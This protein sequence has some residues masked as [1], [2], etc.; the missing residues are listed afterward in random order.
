M[1]TT[2]KTITGDTFESISIRQYGLTTEADRIRKANPG[3]QEPLTAGLSLTIPVIPGAP[4]NKTQQTDAINESE[5]ALL[6]DNVRFRFWD[7]VRIIRTIDAIDMVEFGAPND[8]KFK[9]ILKPFSYK[10][11]A[12]TINEDVMFT[13]NMVALSPVLENKRK[14]VSVSCYSTPGVLN[15]CTAP[16]SMYPLEFN[17]TKLENIV[18][19]LCE[20]FGV[21]VIV[22]A[23]TGAVFDRATIDPGERIYSFITKLA[24][25]RNIIITNDIDGNLLLLRSI[26]AGSPVVEME[27]GTSPILSITPHFNEQNYYSHITGIEPVLV[28][29]EGS[30]FTVKNSRLKGVV[31]PLTFNAPD[32]EN[33]D[34]KTAVESKTGRMFG[35]MVSYNLKVNTWR[36]PSGK[37]WE[38]NTTLKLY[39]PDVFVY[40]YYEFIIRSV[41][42]NRDKKTETA[43]INLVLPGS[44]SGEIPNNL[45]WD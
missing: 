37:L 39:A 14:I 12:I 13:G 23:D 34:L 16:A 2:Y 18:T 33:A 31:R 30:Q 28:G 20:P 40:N 17:E 26:S 41:E 36:D 9:D 3:A 10:T 44:F 15:D 5:V 1:S 21:N 45:P 35:N 22:E 4:K 38:P 7:S 32:T 24:Q 27:Q 19:K 29:F 8:V 6:I 43:V 25:Q 42:F 11:V